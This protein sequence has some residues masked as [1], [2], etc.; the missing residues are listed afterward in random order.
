[1]TKFSARLF[2]QIQS[3]SV[4]VYL[5]QEQGTFKCREYIAALNYEMRKQYSQLLQVEKNLTRGD[6][7]EYRSNL[8]SN[9][10]SDIIKLYRT[11]Q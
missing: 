3:D 10:Q 7:V 5:N 9:K 8:Y 1:M 6:D 4:K 11:V 2:C